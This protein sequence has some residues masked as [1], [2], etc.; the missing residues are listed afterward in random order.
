[1]VREVV[2]LDR[3][4]GAGA[5]VQIERRDGRASC[6]HALEQLRREM[7]SGSGRRHAAVVCRIHRLVAVA[8]FG[9]RGSANVGRQRHLAVP[10]ERGGGIERTDEFYEPQAPAQNLDDLDRAVVAESYRDTGIELPARVHQSGTG[11]VMR[12]TYS[13]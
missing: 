13:P 6:A 10:G 12:T 4:E 9:A 7:Q 3:L 2:H 1:M 5:D 8:I 11:P